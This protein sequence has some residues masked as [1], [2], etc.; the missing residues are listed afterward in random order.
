[1][2]YP[3][4]WPRLIYVGQKIWPAIDEKKRRNLL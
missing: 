4:N 1:M 2:R 3:D